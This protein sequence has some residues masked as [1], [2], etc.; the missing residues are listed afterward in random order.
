MQH[1]IVSKF[2][3]FQIQFSLVCSHFL[4]FIY[5]SHLKRLW[6]SL[7]SHYQFKHNFVLFLAA[8]YVYLFHPFRGSS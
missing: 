1:F 3:K 8:L 4:T 6:N 7:R 2:L 5:N